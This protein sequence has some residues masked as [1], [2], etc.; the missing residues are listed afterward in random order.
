MHTLP[1]LQ[2]HPHLTPHLC[3]TLAPVTTARLRWQLLCRGPSFA[4]VNVL[5]TRENFRLRHWVETAVETGVLPQTTSRL[6][7]LDLT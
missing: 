6:F 5:K 3:T 1:L 7:F 4:R 2:P